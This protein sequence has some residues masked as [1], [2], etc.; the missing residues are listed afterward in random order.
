MIEDCKLTCFHEHKGFERDEL[1]ESCSHVEEVK[2]KFK[3]VDYRPPQEV[4]PSIDTSD[5]RSNTIDSTHEAD[6]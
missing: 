2:R 3:V 5:S 1:Y 6:S 4:P